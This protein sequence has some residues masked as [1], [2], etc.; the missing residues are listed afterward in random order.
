MSAAALDEKQ[1]TLVP[2]FPA[3]VT[4]V[5]VSQMIEITL[6]YDGKTWFPHATP[7]DIS[8]PFGSYTQITWNINVPE[9]VDPRSVHFAKPALTFPD[10]QPAAPQL[11]IKDPEAHRL[12]HTVLWANIDPTLV[13]KFAYT[14]NIIVDGHEVRIDPTVEN[15]SP[16]GG[17]ND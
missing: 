6:K 1:P 12:Q 15:D 17:P 9:D 10:S 4:I 2:P 14:L 7:H 3:T 13:G 11:I 16:T 8:I 5:A